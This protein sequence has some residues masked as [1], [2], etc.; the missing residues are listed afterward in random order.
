M[1]QSQISFIAGDNQG[2][3]Y[4][5]LPEQVVSVGRSHSNT[6]RLSAPDVSGKHLIIRTDRKGNITVE[7]LSSRT[8]VIDGKNAS[9]GDMLK[10]APGSTVQMGSTTVFVIESEDGGDMR[11]MISSSDDEKTALPSPGW[12]AD[13]DDAEKTTMRSFDDDATIQGKSP[14]P[15]TSNL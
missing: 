4:P 14:V 7:I 11:T 10:L 3:K 2:E 9:I 1:M 15:A 12:K 13:S 5:L 8:T 6:I